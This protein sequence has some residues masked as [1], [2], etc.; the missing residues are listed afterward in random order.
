LA[1]KSYVLAVPHSWEDGSV[2]IDTDALQE[3]LQ[4]LLARIDE[5]GE[6]VV[7]IQSLQAGW[8][9]TFNNETR[10]GPVVM[11]VTYGAGFG[12]SFTDALVVIT[13]SA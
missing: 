13:Q 4:L 9:R 2:S 11:S 3:Q 12:F 5:A 6:T 8:G 1:S 10:S 7:A